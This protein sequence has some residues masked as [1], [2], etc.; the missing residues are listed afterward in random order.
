MTLSWIISQLLM[1]IYALFSAWHHAPAVNAMREYA[2][3]PNIYEDPFHFWSAGQVT[4]VAICISLG[5]L[6]YHPLLW[7]I[8]SGFLSVA[9]YWLLF[10][11]V[12][13][14]G[15]GKSW[16]YLGNDATLDRFLKKRFGKT[17]GEVK[18][19]CL[20]VIILIVNVLRFVL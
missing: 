9:W 6:S 13:N 18:A 4:I 7:C 14:K 11:I 20:V 10:D 5:I 3:T 17:G 8:V 1:I 16:D 2:P 19:V 15:T 12:L